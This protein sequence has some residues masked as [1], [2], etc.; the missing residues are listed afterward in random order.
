M[1]KH[2]EAFAQLEDQM[3]NQEIKFDEQRQGFEKV[4][5]PGRAFPKAWT[6]QHLSHHRP[7]RH[8]T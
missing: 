6:L 5:P 4:V 1:H 2:E 7:T 8:L 3:K